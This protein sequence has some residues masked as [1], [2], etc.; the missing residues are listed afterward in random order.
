MYTQEYGALS[1][2]QKQGNPIKTMDFFPRSCAF[3]EVLGYDLLFTCDTNLEYFDTLE[4]T[5]QLNPQNDDCLLGSTLSWSVTSQHTSTFWKM[6][7]WRGTQK[8][9]TLIIYHLTVELFF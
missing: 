2:K 3:S 5:L 1:V 6:L 8:Y 7:D 9:T 4:D